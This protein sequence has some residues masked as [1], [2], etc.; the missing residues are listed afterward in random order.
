LADL[1]HPFRM[2]MI[3]LGY[4]ARTAQGYAYV[5]ACL[6]RWL[7]RAGM[8]PQRLGAAEL[9]EFVRHRRTAGC[10]RWL[11]VRSL[12]EML[13]YLRQVGV[14]PPEQA[15]ARADGPVAGLVE[16]YAGY[17]RCERRLAETTITGRVTVADRYLRTLMVEDRL[18]VE[19]LGPQSVVDF[20]L[21]AS[22]RYTVGS[23]K[24]LTVSLRSLLRYLFAV[25]VVDRDLSRAVPSVAGWRIGALPP[26]PGE[27]VLAALLAACDRSR[28]VGLRDNAV[29]LLMARLGLRSAEIADLRLDDLDWRSGEVVVRGKGGRVDRLP[30]P[31]D[32][33]AA[34]VEYLRRGRRHSTLRQVFVRTVGPDAP[35]SRQSVVMVP[36]CASR[37]A[38]IGTVA[39]HQ[40]RH[41]AACRV[42]AE[43]GNLTEVA[44]LLRH[45]A[46]A[47]AAI[48]AKVDLA[49]LSA[50][51]R[52]WPGQG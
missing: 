48:Y 36:R 43:G 3:R 23:M 51:A 38:G 29:L 2:E 26:T 19:L 18:R 31:A 40:L 17:L 14:I 33:G 45:Q 11:S 8:V 20:V 47:T 9:E 37:R 50:A 44:Q 41:R 28:P 39:A 5:L 27:D 35:M 42:L 16:R 25:G 6:S 12:R 49:A 7:G 10:R 1:V 21:D 52:A 30:L 46:E 4:S 13:A 34:L 15:P 24:V 32:V 22:R